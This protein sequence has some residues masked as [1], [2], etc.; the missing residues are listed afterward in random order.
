MDLIVSFNVKCYFFNKR[1]LLLVLLCL[2]SPT[3]LQIIM[4]RGR[5]FGALSCIINRLN[6]IGCFYVAVAAVLLLGASV[7]AA[8][9]EQ[10]WR[11][12]ERAH[13]YA[14]SRVWLW[15]HRLWSYRYGNATLADGLVFLRRTEQSQRQHVFHLVIRGPQKRESRR[16][17]ALARGHREQSDG[18]ARRAVGRRGEGEGRR[19]I[20]HRSWRRLQMPGTC[21]D[22]WYRPS[23]GE[24]ASLC[25]RA[26]SL[27]CGL[28]A[29]GRAQQVIRGKSPA[30]P[31]FWKHTQHT[32]F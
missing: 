28:N 10:P 5:I 9:L 4:Q 22:V 26:K 12:F 21:F 11:R 7:V 27:F 20:G 23:V 14:A 31:L 19:F 15:H 18:G 16:S 25:Q 32:V 1:N 17:E 8:L 29:S 6:A 2:F 13:S 24:V 3:R 30:P